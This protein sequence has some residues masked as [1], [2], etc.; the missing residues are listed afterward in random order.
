MVSEELR[1]RISLL[2]RAPAGAGRP[3]AARRALARQS[4][5]LRERLGGGRAGRTARGKLFVWE[6]SLGEIYSDA[7]RLLDEY[8][9]VFE[10]ASRL[11]ERS[12]LPAFLEPL[13]SADAG[14]AAFVDTET[15]GL[16]GR[17]LFLIG[18]LRY[19]GGDLKLTQ[20][21][22]R[23]YPEEA[24]ILHKFAGVLRRLRLLIT[25]NGK[26]FDWPFVRDRMVY[27]RLSCDPGFGHLDLLH[28]SRRRWRA[29]LPNC[30][31][32]T[33]ERYLCGRWR[34][35]DIAGEEIPQRYHDFVREQDARLIA[36]IFH[37]NRLDLITMVELLIALVQGDEHTRHGRRV[38]P[39]AERAKG[40]RDV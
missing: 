18:V 2:Q 30:K 16:H 1:R 5:D 40:A 24:A 12:A 22:A 14:G 31:L 38:R 10:Q 13:T 3:A 11:A 8:L 36:P 29:Q 15:T 35:G 7:G 20:Y 25:F 23:S 26:A 6:E 28:P 39:P 17:P 27:H 21:F 19:R 37:H 32:Q 34:S 9:G 33:L 4:R